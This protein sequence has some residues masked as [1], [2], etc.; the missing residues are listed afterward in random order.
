MPI[1]HTTISKAVAKAIE[2]IEKDRCPNALN[3]LKR[4]DAKLSN[5]E[6]QKPRKANPYAEF[7][8]KQFPHFQ[9]KHPGVPA[10]KLMSLIAQ[11]WKSEHKKESPKRQ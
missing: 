2:Q 8:K 7:V 10:V 4:L 9:K 11:A 5:K 3:T 1:R 6:K